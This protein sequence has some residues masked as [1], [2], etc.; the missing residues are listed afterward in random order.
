MT[1][2]FRSFKDLAK[3]AQPSGKRRTKYSL[4]QKNKQVME[5]HRSSVIVLLLLSVSSFTHGQSAYIRA[6]YQK[7]LNQH[8]A[9]FVNREMCTDVI[10]NR[11]IVSETGGCKPVNTFIQANENQITAVCGRNNR[12]NNNLFQNNQQFSVVT[13]NLRSG[14]WPNCVYD[15]GRL[16]TRYIVLACEQGL[17]VHYEIVHNR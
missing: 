6:R 5:I 8:L 14:Q 7:F 15:T 13:C 3:G 9:P 12:L 10:R 11:N 1:G 16:S 17:P 4:T 2:Y